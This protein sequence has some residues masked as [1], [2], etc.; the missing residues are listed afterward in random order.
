M[1]YWFNLL[2]RSQG[3]RLYWGVFWA[4]FSAV[5]AVALLALSGWFITATALTGVAITAGVFVRFDMYLPGSG[6]RFFALSRTVGRYV[7]RI[8]NHD[9]ILR[10][11]ST[12]RLRLFKGLSSLPLSDL[13]STSDSEWLGKLTADL[14]SLDSIL[15]RYTIPP[16]VVTLLI[17]TLTLFLS[18]IWLELALYLGGFLLLC[19]AVVIG[20]TISQTK[21]LAESSS[22]LLS[23]LRANIIE[24]L[25]GAFV[26]QSHGLMERHETQILQRLDAFHNVEKLLNSTLANI[27]LLLDFIL[28]LV[29]I[30]LVIVGLYSVESGGISGPTAV[31]L[32]MLFI[33]VSEILQSLP[34]QFS[35]WGK[36]SFSANRLKTLVKQ[37]NTESDFAKLDIEAISVTVSQHPKIPISQKKDL[38]F[39]IENKQINLIYGRSGAGK[40]T[41]ANL[42]VGTEEQ[43]TQSAEQATKQ[44]ATIIVNANTNLCEISSSDWHSRLGYLDQSNSILAGTLGYNLALGLPNVSE[45]A[46][47]Q[48]LKLVE[49][50]EWANNLPQ[51]LNT[52]L[53]ET[54]GKVSGGQARRICLCRLILRNPQLVV[55]DEPFNGMDE[56]MAARIWHN[57]SPWLTSKMVVL[58]THERPLFLGDQLENEESAKSIGSEVCLDALEK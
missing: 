38:V 47:W 42:L 19:I 49:L 8:Y 28:G 16:I 18:F 6:I 34:S 53:G 27:Q 1:Q 43:K 17:L 39:S 40:S 29:L 30:V 55:L 15:I 51:G 11:I 12:F 37:P 50:Q 13:R 7:E 23:D 5:S 35:T 54:G 20:L 44:Q 3:G 22:L 21:T 57:I 56:T 33:G 2:I 32:A 14:D 31:M 52:W 24:H 26:L 41:L 4:F 25:Q 58:L 36:T 10:L 48:A 9:T 46:V 45:D